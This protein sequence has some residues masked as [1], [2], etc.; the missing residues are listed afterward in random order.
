MKHKRT[1]DST[2]DRLIQRKTKRLQK[3]Q[4]KIILRIHYT[5]YM[6]RVLVA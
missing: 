4:N 3:K 2:I 6:Y 1:L 5:L